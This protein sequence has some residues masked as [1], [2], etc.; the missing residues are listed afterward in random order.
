MDQVIVATFS[1]GVEL[2]LTADGLAE[3]VRILP[4][5]QLGWFLEMIVIHDALERKGATAADVPPG[6]WTIFRNWYLDFE[7]SSTDDV[8]IVS[9][10]RAIARG[11]YDKAGRMYREAMWNGANQIVN[12]KYAKTGI[13]RHLQLVDFGKKGEKASKK[14]G[15]ENKL[16]VLKFAIKILE[17]RNL[18]ISKHE[19]AEKICKKLSE[20][21]IELQN[22]T[23]RRHLD[24]LIKSGDLPTAKIKKRAER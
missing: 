2:P 14:Q 13:Q 11:E 7:A 5:Q 19:L 18:L 9:C 4:D 15:E 23:I 6:A 22:S 1:N 17:N 10:L 21:S 16:E 20:N 12:E 3:A 24:A 8:V